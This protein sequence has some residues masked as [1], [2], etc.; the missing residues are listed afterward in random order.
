M[1][2]NN[3]GGGG[4]GPSRPPISKLLDNCRLIHTRHPNLISSLCL[5]GDEG[6][7]FDQLKA[8][9]SDRLTAKLAQ[10]EARRQEA[11][12]QEAQRQVLADHGCAQ[13]LGESSSGEASNGELVKRVATENSPPSPKQYDEALLA[14]KQSDEESHA[15]KDHGSSGGGPR[16][17]PIS[18][19]MEDSYHQVLA[20]HGCAQ[21]LGESSSGE[22][23]NGELVKRVA[24]ENSPPSPKQSDKAL[25]ARKQSDEA[26]HDSGEAPVDETSLGGMSR[27]FEDVTERIFSEESSDHE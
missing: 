23:S 15:K 9:I 27:T 20:D 14:K 12:R 7:T 8:A 5:P 11:R 2:N 17:P 13:E 18:E 16:R 26:S 4:G 1:A 19:A 24:T 25:R 10:I 6:L 21:E 22:A 3:H